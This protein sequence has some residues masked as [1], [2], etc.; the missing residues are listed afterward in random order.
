MS[1]KFK[2]KIR[3][4]ELWDEV[5]RITAK[6]SE[7]EILEEIQRIIDELPNGDIK[8]W[9][10]KTKDEI[11]ISNFNKTI[12]LRKAL[13]RFYFSI[14]VIKRMWYEKDNEGDNETRSDMVCV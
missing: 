13:I 14:I 12:S 7:N 1:W 5:Q 9:A 3:H 4:K 11:L 8:Q 2:D 6:L 10:I